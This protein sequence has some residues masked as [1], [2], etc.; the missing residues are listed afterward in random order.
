MKVRFVLV[1]QAHS[2]RRLALMT[3]QVVAA[4]LESD[5]DIGTAEAVAD[6]A[7]VAHGEEVGGSTPPE[8]LDIYTHTFE[9]RC[10]RAL[11]NARWPS[12]TRTLGDC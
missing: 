7:V 3:R 5:G 6:H 11:S 10:S 8:P 1:R 9:C 4:D 2:N 12:V